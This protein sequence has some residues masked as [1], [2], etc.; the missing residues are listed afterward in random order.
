MS[1]GLALNTALTGIQ[2]VQTALQVSSNNIANANT[3]GF[4]RKS[5]APISLLVAG[6]GVGVSISNISRQVNESLIRDMRSQL[7]GIG[8]LRI[9]DAFY[10]R[11][12]DLFGSLASGT[13]L[14]ASVADLASAFEALAASPEDA[15]LRQQV[16][17]EALVLTRQ[18]NNTAR[19]IQVM[20]TDADQ[21]ISASID[22]I[23]TQL[24]QISDLNTQIAR[25]QAAGQPTANLED[26][27][28]T[29][30]TKLA[31]FVDIGTFKK[32]SGE[33]VVVL[34]TG[35]VL[36]D[37]APPALAHTAAASLDVSVTYPGGIG[38]I[39]LDGVDI[40][41]ELTG[42]SIG[43]QI[44]MRDTTLPNQ[45]AELNTLANGIFTEINRISNDGV[46]F[47][48]PNT[49]TG[50]RTI[51]GTDAF[52]ATGTTNIA[53]TDASGNLVA[54][55]IQLNLAAYATVGAFVTALNT[56]LGA[57]GT[58]SIVNGKLVVDATASANGIAINENDTSV[59]GVGVSQYFGLNDFFV[60]DPTV[61]LSR[62]ITV[63][64]DIAANPDLIPR[65]ELNPTAAL[66][67]DSAVTS[68]DN[69][70]VQRLASQ[71]GNSM[72]FAASGNLAATTTTFGDYA[73][74]MLSVNATQAAAAK[75]S[76]SFNETLFED[77]RFRADSASGVSIDEEMANLITLQNSYAAIARV[78]SVTSEMMDTLNQL[79]R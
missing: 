29:A 16:V 6:Q 20:R 12:Q 40:T 34:K 56:A 23:N 4:T 33:L 66:V 51:A 67:G 54:V 62:N 3:E 48:P 31:E 5:V 21:G 46:A 52:T 47:P 79:V 30:I 76:L 1:L 17:G 55:P 36:L 50:T 58:A 43:A 69:S 53:V 70:V 73:A 49:L 65:G 22:I 38:G 19:D 39:T 14:T 42:A 26:K 28:D 68:G 37:G 78:I 32:S 15:S 35:R 7:A 75:D 45:A 10:T 72:S 63:R 61:S 18:F 60:G 57:N 44:K 9:D 59:G 8:S 71:F 13:S 25:D 41:S 24:S 27:R 11:M 64:S 74:Q 77:I 2:T